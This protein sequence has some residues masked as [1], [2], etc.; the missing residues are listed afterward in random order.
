MWGIH[1]GESELNTRQAGIR[2]SAIHDLPASWGSL[3]WSER[4]AQ[5]IQVQPGEKHI[6]PRQPCGVVPVQAADALVHSSGDIEVELVKP[7]QAVGL[8][9][10]PVDCLESRNDIRYRVKRI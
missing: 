7:L 2:T 1:A 8:G 9:Q 10:R 5:S 4:G 6:E 3:T